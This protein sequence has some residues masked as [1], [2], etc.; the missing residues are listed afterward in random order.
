MEFNKDLGA[1]L[2]MSFN[3][4]SDDEAICLARAANI[5][6]RDM[7]ML[8]LQATFVGSFDPDCQV[9]PHALTV[10]IV[11]DGPQWP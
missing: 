9:V 5:A 10:S 7:H 3:Q 1:A 8:K 6:W 4:D 2:R 11:G